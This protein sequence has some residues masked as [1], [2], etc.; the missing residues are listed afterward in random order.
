MIAGFEYGAGDTESYV[1]IHLAKI[2]FF[3]TASIGGAD[4]ALTSAVLRSKMFC[5]FEEI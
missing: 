4:V 3:R 2:F 1:S 5:A